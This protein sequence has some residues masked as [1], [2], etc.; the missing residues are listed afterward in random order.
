MHEVGIGGVDWQ[1]GRCEWGSVS[2]K[3][4]QGIGEGMGRVD[5]WYR[6]WVD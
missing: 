4:V 1:G 3:G 5:K 2:G 6:G